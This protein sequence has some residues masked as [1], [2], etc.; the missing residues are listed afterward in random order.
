MPPVRAYVALGSNLGNRQDNLAL[1]RE[2][3]ATL[4]GVVMRG[5]SA[6]E[7]TVP[8]GGLDQPMYLNQMLALDTTLSPREL[9]A[10]CQRIEADAGGGPRAHWASRILDLDI[11]RYGS[12]SLQEPDLIVPH[13]GIG[14]RDFW[15]R[16][17]A[18]LERMGV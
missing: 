3:L 2:R 13:P 1:A 18:E 6:V 16:E 14:H 15:Q 4:P 17:L 11:V 7:E 8:L 9:L 10:A 5:E 12:L